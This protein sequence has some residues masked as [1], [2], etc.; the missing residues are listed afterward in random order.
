MDLPGVVSSI[1]ELVGNTPM[2]RLPFTD[3]AERATVLAK[4]EMFNPLSNVKDRPALQMFR[5]AELSGELGPGGTVIEV[6]SGSTGISLA[7]LSAARGYRCIIVM[8]DNATE[9]RKKIL[10]AFGAEVLLFPAQDGLLPAWE[11]AE[12]LRTDTPGA[13]LA[14]QDQNP[15]NVYS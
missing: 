9:E 15:A 6:S 12:K 14:H 8:P 13:W 7:A 4:L 3:L 11:F 2:M 1:E 10:R 5:D